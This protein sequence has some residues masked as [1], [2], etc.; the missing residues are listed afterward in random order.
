M[1]G[2]SI[3]QRPS[4]AFRAEHFRPLIKRQIAGYQDGTPFVAL[5]E[6]LE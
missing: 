5:A 3:K 6:D 1:M 2:E 4:Q